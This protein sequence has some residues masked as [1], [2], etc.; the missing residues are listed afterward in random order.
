MYIFN[1][2][3]EN[4]KMKFLWYVTS[5][6][7]IFLILINNPKNSGNNNFGNQNNLI[8]LTGNSQS[9]L[10]KIIMVNV[11]IFLLITIFSIID[12]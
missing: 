7:T 6:L 5:I 8:N 1:F 10:Q 12:F 4:Y 11:F 9:F 3:E 2:Y